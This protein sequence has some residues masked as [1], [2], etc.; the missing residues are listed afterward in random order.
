MI[1]SGNLLEIGI[2]NGNGWG[3][4]DSE[5]SNLL[6]SLPG[7]PLKMCSGAET[8]KNEHHCDYAWDNNA[9]I[10]KIVSAEKVED[11]IQATAE[12]TDPDVQKNIRAG[13]LSKKWSIFTGYQDKLKD[14]LQNTKALSVTLVR[15]PA[16]PG[17][18]YDIAPDPAIAA[19]AA[20]LKGMTPQAAAA[21][22][23]RMQGKQ[24][25]PQLHKESP[26][27][28]PQNPEFSDLEK[29]YLH[30]EPQAQKEN[31]GESLQRALEKLE[32]HKYQGN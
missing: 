19:I 10:G 25:N 23:E 32:K 3:I 24:K 12:V 27:P 11:W 13:N 4:P 2:K 20:A 28:T 26:G 22:I 5:T 17:A 6:E 1:I 18:G 9:Q 31:P 14:M 16:Y 29:Y 8:L 21:A 30:P 15:N 7:V